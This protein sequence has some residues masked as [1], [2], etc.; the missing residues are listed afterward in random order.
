MRLGK[1]GASVARGAGDNIRFRTV[2]RVPLAGG[3]RAQLQRETGLRPLLPG[4]FF[5]DFLE[6]F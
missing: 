4:W 1:A 3:M 2:P 6:F 5:D